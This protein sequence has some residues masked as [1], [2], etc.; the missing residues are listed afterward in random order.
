M[1]LFFLLFNK[2]PP[3]EVPKNCHP[4]G[5]QDH[6]TYKEPHGSQRQRKHANGQQTVIAVDGFDLRLLTDL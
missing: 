1:K 4:M 6:T 5:A 2:P 3:P